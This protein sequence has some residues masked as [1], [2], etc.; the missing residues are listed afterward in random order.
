[1]KKFLTIV[2]STIALSM[3]QFVMANTATASYINMDLN[4]FS[5]SGFELGGSMELAEN[6][7][8]NVKTYS[9]ANTINGYDITLDETMINVGYIRN[10]NE[11]FDA[12]FTLGSRNRGMTADWSGYSMALDNTVTVYGI[13]MHT[14]MNDKVNLNFGLLNSSDKGA[15]MVTEFGA[16][17]QIADNM[18]INFKASSEDLIESMAL[19]LRFKF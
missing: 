10:I 15:S 6:I 4:G 16:D 8:L 2:I 12:K 11:T 9:I 13:Q 7:E 18:M 1:M 3:P 14:K 17:F 19:G 5:F